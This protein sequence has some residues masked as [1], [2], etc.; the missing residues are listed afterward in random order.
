VAQFFTSFPLKELQ[1][2]HTSLN[3]VLP[4]DIKVKEVAAAPHQF[5]PRYSAKRK[6]YHY[7]VHCSPFMDP[8]QV[9]YSLHVRQDLKVDAMREAA[10]YFVGKHDF[11]AFANVSKQYFREGSLREIYKFNIAEGVCSF[12]S[13]S[14]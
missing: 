7:K 11:S 6:L 4:S 12:F 9:R 8:F 2:L 5:H 14:I 1:T 10:K 13:Q 3:G